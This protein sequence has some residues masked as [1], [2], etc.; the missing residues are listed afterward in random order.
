MRLHTHHTS[1]SSL[2]QAFVI[3]QLQLLLLAHPST[4]QNFL[5]RTKRSPTLPGPPSPPTNLDILRYRSHHGANL[6]SIFVLEKWLFPAMFE[7][8]A[9]GGSELDAV[10]A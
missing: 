8:G 3:L 9:S 2:L 10:T 5:N 4:M 6:G 7:P 1:Q